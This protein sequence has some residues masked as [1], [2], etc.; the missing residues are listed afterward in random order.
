MTDKST[1]DLREDI[2]NEKILSAI[3]EIKTTIDQVP[4][5]LDAVQQVNRK[6]DTVTAVGI[7]TRCDEEGEDKLL[8]PMLDELGY[9]YH[10]AKTN[11]GLGRVTNVE[12]PEAA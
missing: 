12:M 2:L 3:V 10:R 1:G 9:S 6:I 7:S 5:V 8:S 11:M 4:A